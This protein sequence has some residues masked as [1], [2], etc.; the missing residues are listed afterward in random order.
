MTNDKLSISFATSLPSIYT[1]LD[2][3]LL[4][5]IELMAHFFC[6]TVTTA[7]RVQVAHAAAVGRAA[8]LLAG[9]TNACASICRTVAALAHLLLV[10]ILTERT[11]N[12]RLT[13]QTN[14]HGKFWLGNG[15]YWFEHL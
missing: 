3:D 6:I 4:R 11:L 14:S 7:R 5:T 15:K 2:G 12:L 1:Q 9:T 8:L 10:Q 13:K